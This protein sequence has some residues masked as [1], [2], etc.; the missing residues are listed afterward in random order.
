MT[1]LPPVTDDSPKHTYKGQCHCGANKFT[2]TLAVPIEEVPSVM[3][4]NC[5]ICQRNGMYAFSTS[6]R[7]LYS[8]ADNA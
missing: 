6:L 7:M 8:R 5:S 2:L 4:C 1:T 3:S